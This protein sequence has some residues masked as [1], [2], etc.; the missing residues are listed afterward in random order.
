METKYGY[1]IER[2]NEAKSEVRQNLVE[3]ARRGGT[4][5]YSEL[6]EQVMAIRLEPDSYALAHMLGEVSEEDAAGRGMLSVI[7]VHKDGDMQPG[8]GFFQLAK[9]PGRDTTDRT[10]CWIEELRQ[11]HGHWSGS[12]R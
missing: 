9:K 12:G 6:V 10:I 5:P 2:W 8:P 1:A 4:I 7:V 11:V 3:R